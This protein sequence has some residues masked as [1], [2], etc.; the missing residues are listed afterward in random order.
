MSNEV[1]FKK[2]FFE[3]LKDLS[4]ITTQVIITKEDGH[5]V[6][7]QKTDDESIRY[8][9]TA[10]LDNFTFEK[11]EV[12]IYNYPEFYQFFSLFKNPKIL[13]EDDKI[14]FEEGNSLIEYYFS[15]PEVC[16]RGVNTNWSKYPTA[17]KFKIL[18]KDLESL[19]KAS[20]LIVSSDKRKKARISVENDMVKIE[21][22]GTNINQKSSEYNQSYSKVFDAEKVTDYEP[23]NYTIN[24]DFFINSAKNTD[25]EVEIK[26]IGAIKSSYK[27]DDICVDIFTTFIKERS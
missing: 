18:Q 25:F 27:V 3:V 20:S 15:K 24:A 19:V 10:P 9:L 23:F 8:T 12:G 21:L 6:C 2:K 16:A 13:I 26:Q 22:I 7:R 11:D 14:R 5:L 17:V 4:K 1:Q